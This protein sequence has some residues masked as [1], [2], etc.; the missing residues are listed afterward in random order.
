MSKGSSAFDEHQSSKKLS[1]GVSVAPGRG[2]IYCGAFSHERTFIWSR[3]VFHEGTNV[4]LCT[5]VCRRPCD[6]VLCWSP[7]LR[8]AQQR[9]NFANGV[10]LSIVWLD[11]SKSW[12]SRE[13]TW[14]SPS[15]ESSCRSSKTECAT[16][17]P[18][19]HDTL[20]LSASRIQ[21]L[22][23]AAVACSS[24]TLV[25]SQL[26]PLLQ[27]SLFAVDI[28]G[29]KSRHKTQVYKKTSTMGTISVHA[30]GHEH[31]QH[32]HRGQ[33]F[34]QETN[35]SFEGSATLGRVKS[36]VE[37]VWE[38]AEQDRVCEM[39]D[40]E[41]EGDGDAWEVLPEKDLGERNLRL[42]TDNEMEEIS[43]PAHLSPRIAERP[44]DQTAVASFPATG[45]S[46]KRNLQTRPAP[47][48][49][50]A[51]PLLGANYIGAQPAS[52]LPPRPRRGRR[53]LPAR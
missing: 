36:Q 32:Y 13:K 46:S 22:F 31:K 33:I 21:L 25:T 9:G 2:A 45:A 8:D 3:G 40:S 37:Q 17:F 48:H 39:E 35:W 19:V 44:S 28:P 6:G 30:S 18:S 29:T 41:L 34:R 49:H 14:R 12:D 43:T 50:L 38:G 10:H 11:D 26:V 24:T 52:D 47:S 23:T 4:A 15:T 42:T 51:G 7:E 27:R 20:Q 16:N 5:H 53:S 1:F